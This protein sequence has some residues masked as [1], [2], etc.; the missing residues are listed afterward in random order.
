MPK[1]L[2][3]K[4]RTKTGG[5]IKG[6]RNKATL[7]REQEKAAAKDALQQAVAGTLKFTPLQ[8]MHAVM[9]LRISRGDD[10]GALAAASEAA[11]YVHAKLNAAEVRVHHSISGRSD[12]AIA[13]EIEMLRLK[14]EAAKPSMQTWLLMKPLHRPKLTATRTLLQMRNMQTTSLLTQVFPLTPTTDDGGPILPFSGSVRR[15]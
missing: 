2:F 9:L 5:K 14:V 6:S 15:L 4:G 1:P 10:Q 13:Q 11:P 8:V 3:Q 7:L 12:D